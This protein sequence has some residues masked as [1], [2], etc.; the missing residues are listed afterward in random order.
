MSKLILFLLLLPLFSF[1]QKEG[2]AKVDSILSVL[3]TTKQDTLRVKLLNELSYTYDNIDPESGLKYGHEALQLAKKLK[4]ANGIGMAYKCIGNNYSTKSDFKKALSFYEK[5]LQSGA[6]KKVLSFTILSIGLVYTYQSNYA[7]AQEYN[8]QA[9]KMLEEI[10][11]QRGIAAVLSNIG[12]VYKDLK[13]FPKALEYFDKALVINSKMGNSIFMTSNFINKGHV[14]NDLREHEKAL[15][16]YNKGIVISEKNGDITNKAILLGSV[17]MVHYERGD[18]EKAL[19][20]ASASLKINEQNQDERN[21]SNNS[22]LIGDIYLDMAQASTNKKQKQDLLNKSKKYLNSSLQIQLKQRNWKEISFNYV[23]LSKI[24]ALLDNFKEANNYSI[25]ASAYKDSVYNEDSKETIKNL[26]D[27][28][29]IEL[30]DKEI[31]LHKLTLQ[32]KEKQ[33]WF[34]IGGILLL[35]IIGSLLFYQSR[36]RRKT[37]EKLQLLNTELDQA[38]KNKTRFFSILNHDLRAPVANLIHFLHLQKENPELL[39]EATKNR[40]QN[41]TIKGAENLL[42][43]MEDIL[44]WS[45]GQMANF[46][47]QPK[48]ITVNQLFE[49]TKKIFLGYHTIKFE[50][51]NPDNSEILTDENYL[52]TIIRNLTSN[53]INAFTTTQNPTIVWKAWHQNNQAFLSVTDNG[54][55]ASLEQ[56]KALYD[57]K[58]V[59]GIKS[60]LGLHLIRDLAKAIDCEISVDSRTNKGTTFIL[61]FNQ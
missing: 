58:E 35:A 47:P 51:H 50:Y 13:K 18:F 38:N 43:S 12:I 55:G 21:I 8:F 56:F 14:H 24:E 28:Q 6:D 15:E 49:D 3:P 20:F 48:K 7:K 31:Q 11:D 45:K 1:G 33:K 53:A 39:D 16:F 10:N 25:K 5:S 57:D 17:A 32:S 27:K 40:M 61:K 4:W 37:N 44:L 46:K 36:N 26:E 34:Y 42:S 22:G 52:K 59:I 9:L 60:G 19:E 41:K 54:S 30:R 29:S 2:Q 23:Q